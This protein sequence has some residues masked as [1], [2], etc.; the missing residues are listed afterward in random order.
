ML[1]LRTKSNKLISSNKEIINKC[2]K[3]KS[4]QRENDEKI[5]EDSKG[6]KKFYII[7]AIRSPL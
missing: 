5:L 3:Q 7:T 4:I 6:S 1:K 2:I